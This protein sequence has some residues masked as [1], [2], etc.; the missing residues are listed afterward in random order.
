MKK[1]MIIVG[2]G[3]AGLSTGCYAQCNGYQSTI[4]EMHNIPGGLCTAW[5]RKGYT[6]DIS[7]HMLVGSK[8]GPAHRMWR[9]LGVMEN[10]QFHYHTEISR[11]EG[12]EKNLTLCTDPGRLLDQLLSLS[13]ADEKLSREFVRLVSGRGMTG[14]MSLRPSEL[15]GLRDKLKMFR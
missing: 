9:E 8:S 1:N 2:A 15:S 7:M 3:I 14:A 4:Y 12:L 5:K 13:P 6:F 10:R 11:I